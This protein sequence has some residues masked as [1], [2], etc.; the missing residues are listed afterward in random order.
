MGRRELEALARILGAQL[1]RGADGVVMGTWTISYEKARDAFL[2][3]KC[4]YGGYCDE[5]P[6]VV[7]VTGAVLDAGGPLL[8]DA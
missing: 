5:R 8:Q 1:Q 2:F 3:D 6:S 4:E 7:S